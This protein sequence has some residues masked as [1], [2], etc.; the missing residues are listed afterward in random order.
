[1]YRKRFYYIGVKEKNFNQVY[2]GVIYIQW[3]PSSLVYC[4]MWGAESL[5]CVRLFVT[6]WT[7][8]HQAPLSMGFYRQEYWSGL[9]IPS[10]GAL[11]NPGIEPASPA[12]AG[13]FFTT[14]LPGKPQQIYIQL[15]NHHNQVST[16]SHHKVSCVPLQ[17]TPPLLHLQ[18]PP[19]TDS[20]SGLLVLPFLDC[21]IN[22]IIHCIWSLFLFYFSELN[23]FQ[24]HPHCCRYQQFITFIAK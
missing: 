24:I 13:R 22:G 20:F 4:V 23:A 17:W 8:D 2:R 19:A 7:V 5:N 12:P 3:I 18:D 11:P 15:C 21:R 6:P 16:P 1:M 9:P 14:E 10:P